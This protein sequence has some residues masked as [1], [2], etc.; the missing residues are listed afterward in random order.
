MV[1]SLRAGCSLHVSF[2]GCEQ[3]I[4]DIDQQFVLDTGY[5]QWAAVNNI[6]VLY[7]QVTRGIG[8]PKGCFD[9]WGYTTSDY[10]V[11]DGPQMAAVRNMVAAMISA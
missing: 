10:V 7:P 8:N 2:H 1:C 11:Q 6:I 5:N 3:T 9:W 4:N